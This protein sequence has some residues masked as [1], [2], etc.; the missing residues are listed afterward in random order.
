M[1]SLTSLFPCRYLFRDRGGGRAL[2]DEGNQ[3]SI[4]PLPS[5]SRRLVDNE[6]EELK[7]NGLTAVVFLFFSPPLLPSKPL[8][9]RSDGRSRDGSGPSLLCFCSS[10]FDARHQHDGKGHEAGCEKGETA[11]PPASP[12]LLSLSSSFTSFRKRP[13]QELRILGSRGVRMPY[14]IGPPL[15]FL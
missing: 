10:A 3:L 2:R 14:K 6:I 4:L 7:A 11:A 13:L 12:F 8:D 15:L 1:M 5:S 9:A